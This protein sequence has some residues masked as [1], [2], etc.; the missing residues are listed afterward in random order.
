[1]MP[2]YSSTRRDLVCISP[3]DWNEVWEGPQELSS[4]F[5]ASGWRVLFVENIGVRVPRFTWQDGRRI[6]SRMRRLITKSSPGASV[7]AGVSVYTPFSLPP[8]KPAWLRRR[9]Q[10]MLVRQIRRQLDGL[11]MKRPVIWTYLPSELVQDVC[12]ALDPCLLVY[13][14][15][16]D[17]SKISSKHA[18]LAKEEEQ[19]L[20]TADMVFVLSRQLFREK[21]AKRQD[22]I[23]LPQG[24]NLQH[25][26]SESLHGTRLA[27]LPRPIVGYIGTIHEWVDQQLVRLAAQAR[28]DWTFVLIG[29]ERVS[30][31]ELRVLKNIVLLGPMSHKRLPDYVAEFDVGIIP[32]VANSFARTVRPNKVLEYF[33]MGKPVVTTLLPEL[34]VFRHHLLSAGSLP[35]FVQAVELAIATDSAI[36]KAERR[37]LAIAN[38]MDQNFPAIE[39]MVLARLS[40]ASAEV[41]DHA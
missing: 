5:V 30:T 40:Q 7:P 22:V 29:P 41:V 4:Q 1:M 13:C 3:I 37:D 33:V 27:N 36:K 8:Y 19:L 32:Y 17:F 9:N 34:D 24:A 18:Y 23:L 12:A 25:Y 2:E 35:E 10:S 16:H 28:P 21:Q 39:A 11:D 6:G 31:S 38:S 26:L 15:V 14:C 20:D